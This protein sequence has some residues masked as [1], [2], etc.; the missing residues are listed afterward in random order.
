M[1]E[2]ISLEGARTFQ[3]CTS[4]AFGGRHMTWTEVHER[5]FVLAVLG[6]PG[7]PDSLVPAS[8]YDDEEEHR[9]CEREPAV[10]RPA[11]LVPTAPSDGLGSGED[12]AVIYFIPGGLN[13]RWVFTTGDPDPIPSVPHGHYQNQDNSE[14]KLNPYTGKAW[15]SDGSEVRKHRL[16]RQ[17]MVYLWNDEAF[18]E[19]CRKNLEHFVS[20]T[21]R[22]G[23]YLPEDYLRFPRPWEWDPALKA[24]WKRLRRK[25]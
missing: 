19:E 21:P 8:L 1:A 17:E 2:A 13:E 5:W 25:H 6:D 15:N 7:L 3:F 18:R 23:D 9:E 12:G 22:W 20:N 11:R 24:H 14:P 4:V 10:V 16:N